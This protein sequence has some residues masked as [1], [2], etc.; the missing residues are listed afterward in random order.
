M[1]GSDDGG[2]GNISIGN[3]VPKRSE[4]D[5]YLS[6]AA[7]SVKDPL[8]WWTDNTQIYPNLSRMARDYLSIPGKSNLF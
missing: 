2:F 3:K 7:E 1:Q 8:K 4:I 5:I 6:L